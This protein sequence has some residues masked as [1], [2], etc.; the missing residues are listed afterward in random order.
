MNLTYWTTY[1]QLSLGVNYYVFVKATD[2]YTN[3]NLFFTFK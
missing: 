2:I 3:N 1:N